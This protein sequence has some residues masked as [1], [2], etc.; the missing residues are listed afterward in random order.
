MV[1]IF[2]AKNNYSDPL[3]QADLVDIFTRMVNLY[4][5]WADGFVKVYDPKK[6][7]WEG[8][9]ISSMDL[10]ANPMAVWPTQQY[11]QRFCIFRLPV[12]IKLVGQFN[13]DAA[14]DWVGN[15]H[16]DKD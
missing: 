6:D 8:F 14:E 15:K 9:E 11:W 1:L 16:G 3:E 13:V 5:R 10:A 7:E 12:V 2:G 4:Q